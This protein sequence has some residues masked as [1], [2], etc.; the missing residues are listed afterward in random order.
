MAD[1]E[2][3]GVPEGQMVPSRESDPGSSVAKDSDTDLAERYN[4]LKAIALK[5]KKKIAEQ[6]AEIEGLKEKGRL[7][8]ASKI[9]QE[10]DKAQDEIER[11]K[12]SEATLK[13]D[14]EK[15]V[16]ETVKL[17]MASIEAA[18]QIQSLSV[19]HK[20]LREKVEIL[21]KESESVNELKT[22]AD[23]LEKE[24]QEARTAGIDAQQEKR[25]LQIL[26][27]EVTD[28]EKKLSDA[29]GSLEEKKAEHAGLLKELDSKDAK[30]E[31]L[32]TQ[33]MEHKK[34]EDQLTLSKES[35]QVSY[36]YRSTNK[37]NLFLYVIFCK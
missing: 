16:E 27:L 9:Q 28:Y 25:Q 36:N 5:L 4:K 32:L 23:Q 10:F 18:S 1:V 29:Y 26:S 11:L 30:I 8:N 34:M 20:T 12:K 6:N 21:E 2:A 13:K 7:Q 15:S 31:N 24:L 14:L 37:F 22:K 35:F 17:K 19:S 3:G 33:I